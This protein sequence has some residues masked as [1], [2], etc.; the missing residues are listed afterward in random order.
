MFDHR[1]QLQRND[2]TESGFALVFA[3]V[4]LLM[5]SL[6]GA[7]A[8]QTSDSELKVAG[9]LQQAEKQF[10]VAEGATNTEAGNVG[11]GRRSFYLISDPTKTMTLL[12]PTTESTFNPGKDSEAD[13]ALS[14]KDNDVTS[15]PWRNLWPVADNDDKFI[16]A[17]TA[18]ALP[19]HND[20]DYRYL[21]TYLYAD[22]PPMGYD[23]NSF[24]GYKF[25]IQGNAAR[26][27]AVVEEGG[28]KV[29]V[30]ASL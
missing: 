11:F 9:G 23:V 14:P 3:L 28:T 17:A 12:T 7:W 27:N 25:R 21:V 26:T 20:L 2:S 6:F 24:S 15:W 16:S 13:A 8:L 1:P 18:K 10:N 22:T 19:A 29:G 30:K 4:V 5:L